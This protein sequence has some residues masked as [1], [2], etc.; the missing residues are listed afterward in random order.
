MVTIYNSLKNVWQKVKADKSNLPLIFFG[1]LLITIP[2]SLGVNNILLVLFLISLFFFRKSFFLNKNLLLL[3]LLFL[4]FS[5][6]YF[7]SIDQENTLK[8]LTGSTVLIL[9]PIGFMF[10][11]QVSGYQKKTILSFY[12]Y[13]ILAMVLYYLIKAVVRYFLT[14]DTEVFFYHGNSYEVDEGLVPIELNA[15]HFSVFVSLA[16]F[17]KL[18]KV[19]KKKIDYLILLMFA[20]FIF[21]LSSKNIILVFGILNLVYLFYFS[22]SAYQ[23]R[24]RNLILFIGLVGVV[25]TFGKIKDRIAIEFADHS[26]KSVS[27]HV[28]HNIPQTV[29]IL[30]IREAWEKEKFTPN[31]FFPGTAFR[32]YQFRLFLDFLKEDHILWTGFGYAASQ[33]KIEEK[34]LEYNVFLGDDKQ[35][36]YQTNNFHNQYVQIFAET[37]VFGFSIIILALVFLFK[38]GMKNKDFLIISFAI[39]MFCV[40]LTE[41]FLWRQRGIVFFTAFYCL[42]LSNNNLK[43][44][45]EN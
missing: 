3:P 7:W 39:L 2:L 1:L 22:T 8:S 45:L 41:S 11:G 27:H 33:S 15:I 4:L 37:G 29:N 18:I 12:S 14:F 26:A 20:V 6:S 25:L 34:G 21:L 23:M 16:Y 17:I 32:I 43:K 36:G 40:F 30:S 19:D 31:D 13:G 9:L 5:V 42:F 10:Y 28:I 35:D 38:N 44:T 24:L